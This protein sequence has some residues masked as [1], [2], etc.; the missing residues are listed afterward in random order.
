MGGPPSPEGHASD[1][2]S[3]G[4]YPSARHR[5]LRELL[6]HD[7][8]LAGCPAVCFCGTLLRVTPTGRYP[9]RCPLKP[10]LSS[11]LATRDCPAHFAFRSVPDPHAQSK[12]RL[13]HE[14]SGDV[15]D[16]GHGA[17]RGKMMGADKPIAICG[18]DAAD[19]HLAVAIRRNLGDLPDR[20]AG[21]ILAESLSLRDAIDAAVLDDQTGVAG[22]LGVDQNRVLRVRRP[23]RRQRRVGG[24]EVELRTVFARP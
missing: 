20:Q 10:G 14:A 3:R 21:A 5:T 17:A 4:V 19:E 22:T 7:F 13:A 23:G 12:R 18:L 9:A 1:L 6:P 24:E 16:D 8:T 11:R 15:V 2:A